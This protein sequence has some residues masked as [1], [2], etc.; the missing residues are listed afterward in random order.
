M[1]TMKKLKNAKDR[2]AQAEQEIP[3]AYESAYTGRVN[4]R[5]D[6]VSG[7][8]DTGVTD[9]VL[10]EAYQSYRDKVAGNAADSAAAALGT[11][12]SLGGGYGTDWTKS[13]VNQ[14]AADQTAGAGT[15]LAELRGK[16]LQ[17]WQ[18]E[19]AGN[20]DMAST[21]LGQDSME[22]SAA[23]QDTANAQTWR[24]YLYGRV[25]QAR[26]EN[27]DF[28][29]NVWNIIKGV[30]NTVK[31][32]YDGY[33]GYT[34]IKLAN[35]VAGQQQAWEAF[36][37]GDPERARQIL[38]TYGLDESMVDTWKE[39][40]TAQQNRVNTMNQAVTFLKAGSPDAART[41]LTQ[42]GMD[43]AIVDNWQGLSDVDK[44][45]L[46]Y[47]L[48]AMDAEDKYGNDTGVQSLLQMAGIDTGSM[49]YSD[50]LKQKDI[51]WQVQL[52]K[53]LNGV[54]LQYQKQQYQMKN[55]YG[56]SGRSG[57]SSGRSGSSSSKTGSSG[58]GGLQYSSSNVTSMMNK[59][60]GMSQNDP[61]YS[62]IL[63]ELRRAGVDVD[64]ELGTGITTKRMQVAANAAQGQKSRGSDEQTIY[65]SLRLQG[66]SEDEIAYAM[67]TLK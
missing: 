9:T 34:Q 44:E 60:A 50:T 35:E 2:L 48:S 55:Q 8:N 15:A 4:D 36:D 31:A 7:L 25:G 14:T 16:A 46:D 26:Q 18:S 19:L 39:N 49:D 11:A 6:K 17:Q 45:K 3:G 47:L 62:I 20:A 67:G 43:T 42:A 56:S 61:M 13:V 23:A 1:S 5:L 59:L 64:G 28:W 66:Y 29:S 58:Y 53:A 57:R 40:Y 38:K 22:R 21:L 65:N 41:T 24:N 30:G 52:Q 27:N 10:D 51:D 54:N 63:G 32:G 33:M 37:A 12:Q